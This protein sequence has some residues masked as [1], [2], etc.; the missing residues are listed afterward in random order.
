MGPLPISNK[1]NKYLIMAICVA[2]KYPDAI[3]VE[4]ITSVT[5]INALLQIFVKT[6]YPKEVQ[7]DLGTFFTSE[8]TLE[9]FSRFG[10]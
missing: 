5:V 1:N 10:N 9:F 7:S 4:N 2:S 6:G 3:P 8:L